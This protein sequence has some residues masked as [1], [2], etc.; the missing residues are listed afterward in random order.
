MGRLAD[1]V[2]TVL[3][4]AKSKV[5]I[6]DFSGAQ[7]WDLPAK[8]TETLLLAG[9]GLASEK[10]LV[11][12][13]AR[14]LVSQGGFD[15]QS[16]GPDPVI[17]E[18]LAVLG[19]GE[20]WLLFNHKSDTQLRDQIRGIQS[21]RKV[22]RHHLADGPLLPEAAVALARA[23]TR[24]IKKAKRVAVLDDESGLGLAFAALGHDVTVIVDHPA[25]GR[26][27]KKAARDLGLDLKTRHVDLEKSLP[28]ALRHA[29]D[30]VTVDPLIS[31]LG[32]TALFCRGLCMAREGGEVLLALN[33]YARPFMEELVETLPADITLTLDEI[34]PRYHQDYMVSELPWDQWFIRA[35][36]AP[37][38]GPDALFVEGGRVFDPQER[39]HGAQELVEVDPDSLT[40][41]NLRAAFELFKRESGMGVQGQEILFSKGMLHGFLSFEGGGHVAIAGMPAEGRVACDLFG[42]TPRLQVQVGTALALNFPRNRRHLVHGG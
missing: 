34:S 26:F 7:S 6:R 5:K 11:E 20:R 3:G 41:E 42:W 31:P 40:E 21:Q 36:G 19:E 38:F 8:T 39:A 22:F 30:L 13:G 23:A 33:P 15:G 28:R 18:R 9:L 32:M 16:R 17:A 24:H 37:I 29:F 14:K 25:M 12:G 35:E 27:Y 1:G 4:K 2:Y 10:A